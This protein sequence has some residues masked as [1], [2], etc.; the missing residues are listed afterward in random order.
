[1]QVNP[2]I[3]LDFANVLRAALRQD[4]DILLVGEIRD[5]ET[6]EISL[7]ASMTGHL[8]LS[9]LHTNDAIS[10]AMRLMD[11]GVEPF[12]AASSLRAIVAQR[13]VR[14]LCGECAEPHTPNAIEASW[15]QRY[16]P[17]ETV[18]A[19]SIRQAKG[20][21]HCNHTGFRGRIG[22]FEMLIIR[23][24]I[25]DALR[26]GDTADFVKL[27]KA[28]EGFQP[29]IINALELAVNGVTTL[30]EVLRVAQ[31]FEEVA[32]LDQAGLLVQED[33][34]QALG[35]SDGEVSGSPGLSLEAMQ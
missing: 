24:D 20:C 9:T 11:M 2:K 13:L 17:P 34:N 32:P 5:V 1:V 4:P 18:G 35:P 30:E 22:V 12:L 21:Q 10:S 26:R 8:V 7:R 19:A 25:A 33:L 14:K 29:L 23:D 3:G 28:Q 31:Q 15:M 6:A 16:L 27:A